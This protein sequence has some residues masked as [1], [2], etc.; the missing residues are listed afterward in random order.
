[1]QVKIVLMTVATV[2]DPFSLPASDA[3]LPLRLRAPARHGETLARPEWGELAPALARNRE[4]FGETETQVGG[5]LLTQLRQSARRELLTLAL[6][7]TRRFAP[8]ATLPA[9]S[10]ELPLVLTGH[11]PVLFHPGVWAKNFAASRLAGEVGGIAVN[12]VV[13]NDTR[14]SVGVSVPILADGRVTRGQINYDVPQPSLPWEEATVVDRELFRSFPQRVAEALRPWGIEPLLTS[15]WPEVV[16]SVE[17]G[18]RL[19]DALASARNRLERR[20]GLSNLEVPLGAVCQTEA[21]HWFCA[22]LLCRLPEVHRVYNDTVTQYRVVNRVRNAQHPVPNLKSEGETLEAP[23]WVWKPGERKRGRLFARAV[24]GAILLTDGER[25][26]ATLPMPASG[27][28]C[29]A[30]RE[31]ARLAATGWKLRTRALTTTLFARVFLAD[32]F[33]HGIG[34]AKYD[35]MTDRLIAKLYGLPAPTFLTLTTTVHLP[36]VPLA[37]SEEQSGELAAATPEDVARVESQI[38]QL[39]FHPEEFLDS[40]TRRVRADL[41]AEKRAL[42]A[43]QLASEPWRRAASV[44]PGVRQPDGSGRTRC[45]RLRELNGLL[46]SG[47]EPRRDDLVRELGLLRAELQATRV[48]KS[49]EFSF[50]LFPETTLRPILMSLAGR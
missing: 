33:V 6:T 3:W 27:D 22:D 44:S 46:F 4:E 35:E 34:G 19:V 5:R 23:F 25:D 12:L 2:T 47:L 13:D 43:E 29:C 49:R 24:D 37:A 1:M 21:F 42:A 17:Q 20:W 39:E 30:A 40:D 7:Y 28:L 41:I 36:L 15:Y 10:E 14:G 48:L 11:Q 32:L 16:T 18:E 8:D 31:L 38:R 9:L 45:Q 50:G 26:V